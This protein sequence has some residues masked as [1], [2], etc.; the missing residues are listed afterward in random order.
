MLS[1]WSMQFELPLWF[2]FEAPYLRRKHGDFDELPTL[3][4]SVSD[5]CISSDP[6]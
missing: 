6:F 4:L 3:L 5:E 1:D 2:D